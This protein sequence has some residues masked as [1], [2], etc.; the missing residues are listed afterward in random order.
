[1][2]SYP[3]IHTSWR[4]IFV[5]SAFIF[6][7]VVAGFS[8][9]SVRSDSPL[10]HRALSQIP[11][12]P[13][14]VLIHIPYLLNNWPEPSLSPSPSPSAT[15]TLSV[16]LL[17]ISEVLY[18]P[19]ADEPAE[20]WIEIYNAGGATLD[21]RQYKIGDASAPG[22]NEG[23][24]K[25]PPGSFLHSG[26]VAIIAHR[27]DLFFSRYGFYPDYEMEN[28]E[29]DVPNMVEYT[30]WSHLQVEL[31]NSGDE[32]IVLNENNR[33]VEA[34]SWGDSTF[35]FDPSVHTVDNGHSIERYPPARDR[36]LA[37]DWRDHPEPAPGVVDYTPPSPTP[38]PTR[39]KTLTPTITR[40][41]TPTHTPTPFGDVLLI[42]E[43]IYNP[44]GT[45]PE[46]EWIELYNPGSRRIFLDSFKLGDEESRGGTEGIF[47]FPGF[48]VIDPGQ[49]VVV[50]NQASTFNQY[51]GFFP[52]FEMVASVPS[53]PDMVSYES[54]AS[55]NVQLSNTAD[56]VVLI[57]GR[58]EIVDSISY[59]TSTFFFDPPIEGIPEGHSIERYPP[60]QDTN[61]AGDWRDQ[62]MPNP[63][64]ISLPIVTPTSSPTPTPTPLPTHTQTPSP[65]PVDLQTSTATAT[66]TP[67][68]TLLPSSTSTT[69]PSDTPL[70]SSTS[71]STPTT[72]ATPTPTHTATR[73]STPTP[74]RTA[75]PT[76]TPTELAG[77]ILL[78]EVLYDPLSIEQ[79]SEWIEIYNAGG[80]PI[81][82]S[83]HKIG[84]EE[85]RA[86][87]EGMLVFPD[88]ALANPGQVIL[89][90]NRAT[91]FYA[92]YGFQP[93]FEM[94]ASDPSIPDLAIYPACA[95]GEISMDNDGD[96]LLLLDNG[97]YLADTL[98]WGNSRW[99]FD[100]PAPDVPEGH[101]LER[102]PADQD[103]DTADDWRDQPIPDPGH[104]NLSQFTSTME[105]T[106]NL[107]SLGFIYEFFRNLLLPNQRMP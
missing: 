48:A 97:D 10:K 62:A 1:M 66:A 73:T 99:A 35:A 43:V 82:L 103:T 57:D 36:N 2:P 40:T 81:D 78:S 77:R 16:G 34:V 20:E 14:S 15:P 12:D 39:T 79:D 86:G 24:L 83:N 29:R 68:N 49:V 42:S 13:P 67:S 3:K 59:G 31:T 75:T 8:T 32:V 46:G 104:V 106:R 28:T 19:S 80:S 61:S 44:I 91:T 63:G 17:L 7:S 26:E 4:I 92:S 47:K 93:D 27:A 101:S 51:N 70:P 98:S 5:I 85:T 94:K 9:W 60:G 6:L 23:M 21:I 45:E 74:T 41:S 18:N 54:W 52:N 88:G 89:I 25:F 84:D 22:Q 95:A 38:S 102:F 105:K 37:A 87:G 65:S 90:A 69:T 71:T 100:P 72:P 11:Q 96:Q 58:D 55:G 33:I 50:A 107:F 56:E 53:V 76:S 64:M 30:N